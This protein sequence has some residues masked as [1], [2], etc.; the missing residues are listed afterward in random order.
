MSTCVLGRCED[1]PRGLLWSGGL[2]VGSAFCVSGNLS[3]C[4]ENVFI[5]LGHDQVQSKHLRQ[6]PAEA[7]T[8]LIFTE[9]IK[10]GTRSGPPAGSRVTSMCKEF[11]SC[12]KTTANS[13]VGTESSLPKLTVPMGKKKLKFV[14]AGRIYSSLALYL[15]NSMFLWIGVRPFYSWVN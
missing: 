5:P 13:P 8:L 2:M 14:I 9:W 15:Q 10:P 12:M 4:K 6:N 7:S 11:P 1:R 3:F